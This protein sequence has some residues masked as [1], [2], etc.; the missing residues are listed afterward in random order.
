MKLN[1]DDDDDDDDDDETRTWSY[2][3]K[4]SCCRRWCR[5]GVCHG[6][7]WSGVSHRSGIGG[8]NH[9]QSR[10]GERQWVHRDGLCSWVS[11]MFAWRGMGNRLGRHRV[12]HMFCFVSHMFSRCGGRCLRRFKL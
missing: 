9:R 10:C 6:L 4:R 1:D 3:Y 8:V 7:G 12:R 2:V 11:S 5:C